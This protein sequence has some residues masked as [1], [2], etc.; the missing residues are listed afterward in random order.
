[1]RKHKVYTGKEVVDQYDYRRFGGSGGQYVFQKDCATLE[2]LRGT[3][4]GLLLDVPCG[5]GM[6]SKVFNEKGHDIIAADASMT[7]LEKTGQRQENIPRVLCDINRLPFE[8]DVF[9]TVKEKYG[10]SVEYVDFLVPFKWPPAY[11]IPQERVEYNFDIDILIFPRLKEYAHGRNY[12]HWEMLHPALKAEGFKTFLAGQPD[13]CLHLDAPAVWDFAD[14]EH[15][16]DATICAIKRARI[17]LGT[18]TGTTFLS[19]MCGKP[20]LVIISEQGFDARGGR[21]GFNSGSYYKLDH[22]KKGWSVIAHWHDYRAIVRECVNI[23]EN[24]S[25]YEKDWSEAVTGISK[26]EEKK[27][28]A[29]AKKRK[30]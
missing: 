18:A 27:R 24:R 16:L 19:V 9:D 7:M 17:R 15:I 26:E 2:F 8:D 4:R 25:R 11:F 13:S 3:S 14:K 30:R 28:R 22:K 20:P 29:K 5:T 12:P 6:Y 23:F 10:A 21:N 1:M